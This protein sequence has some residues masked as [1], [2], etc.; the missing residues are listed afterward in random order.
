MKKLAALLILFIAMA[1]A[2]RAGAQCTFTQVSGTVTDPNGLPYSNGTITAQL[3]PAASTPTCGGPTNYISGTNSTSLNVNGTFTMSLAANTAITPSGTHWVFT[4]TGTSGLPAPV[5][6]GTQTF[7]SSATTI[8]GSTQSLTSTLSALAPALTVALGITGGTGISGATAGQALIAGSATTATSSVAVPV[9]AIVGTSDTQTLSSKTFVAPALGTPLSGVLTN[10]TG[11]PLSTGVTGLLPHANIAS[12]AV[13]PGAYTNANITVGADGSI[14]AAANGTGGSGTPCTTTAL[15]FQYN[16]AGS[17]GCD[18]DLTFTSPHT[19]TLGAS[20]IFTLAAG[21]TLNGLTAGMMPTAIPIANVGSAGLSG[22]SP[23]TINSAGAIGC[24]TCAPLA[25]PSFTGTPTGPTAAPATN[26]TQLATTAFVLANGLTNPMTTLGDSITGGTSGA[27]TRLPGPTTPNGVPQTWTSTPAG[28]VATAE[29]WAVPGVTVDAQSSATPAVTATDVVKMV[30]LTNSTTS[31]ALGVPSGATLSSGFA[32]AGCNTG[33]VVATATPTTSTVNGNTTQVMQGKPSGG[34]PE[35]SFW[36]TDPS[37]N[38]WSAEILPTDASGRLA[39]AGMPA[40]T[41]DATNTAGALGLTLATVNSNVGSF[42]NANITVDGKGRITAAA[43]GSGGSNAFPL[44]VTGGVSGALPCFTSTTVEA[45]GTLLAANGLVL[46]GGA[47][48]CPSTTA[49]IT[50]NGTNQLTL[51][52]NGTSSGTIVLLGSTSSSTTLS[53]SATGVLNLGS[54]NATVNGAG[55]LTV[56]SCSGCGSSGALSGLTAATAANTLA[57]G[58]N[59]QAWNFAQ[60]TGSQAALTLGE[61]TAASGTGDIELSLS[62]APGS[63]AV[64][65]NISQNENQ[66]TGVSAINISTTINNASNSAPLFKWTLT[67]T[68]SNSPLFLD[69]LGGTTG[70]TVEYV[71]DAS[72]N[73]EAGGVIS[74][75]VTTNSLQICG[76]ITS[77]TGNTAAQEGGVT[78]QGSDQSGTVST[79]KAGQAILRG[80][81][82]TATTPNAAALEGPVQ[83]VEGYLKGTAVAAIG[84]VLCGTTTAFTITDCPIT[85]GTNIIGIA[86][87]VANPIGVVSYGMAVVATDGAATIGDN[88]CMGTTTAGKAHDNGSTTTACVLGTSIG[89]VIATTGTIA[90]QTGATLGTIALSTTLPL[91]QLHIGQ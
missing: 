50:S 75:T 15:S 83:V 22:T 65:L 17:F 80:G 21:A 5:G 14:T 42:T 67:N 88:V 53:A 68:T 57:N 26:T 77:C 34:N 46:G 8:T 49:G 9:G 63:T 33:T 32:F 19:M 47:G 40:F 27:A 76:G 13:T 48:V 36:W 11:L 1:I 2:P 7:S 52:V 37:N 73:L 74:S 70:T 89:V 12:T 31:T 6:Q 82:L 62:T 39:A 86:T 29:A 25:S 28:G 81:F 30:Q 61:T 72:G 10:A 58:N 55:A 16:A 79:N 4:V 20:G 24:A 60:T 91:V 3:Q 43:N 35:C 84:D 64:P 66:A 51:G 56:A 38:Y 44:T 90:S 85:P 54:T 23:I 59:P 18:P 45:A 87:S 69:F 71:V 41:G 78:I